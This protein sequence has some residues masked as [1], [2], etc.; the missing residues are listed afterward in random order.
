MACNSPDLNPIENLWLD[1]PPSV[2]DKVNEEVRH[3]CSSLPNVHLV[4]HSSIR[5]WH[6]YDGLHLNQDGVRIFAKTIKD[7]ALGRFP[8]TGYKGAKRNVRLQPFEPS[9]PSSRS[10]PPQELH[11]PPMTSGWSHRHQERQP[12]TEG[13]SQHHGPSQQTPSYAQVVSQQ[14]PSAAAAQELSIND[15]GEI[16]HLL[17]LLCNKMLN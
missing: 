12:Y 16:K 5:P 15:M 11:R 3:S 7:V 14:T 9:G 8:T 17:S 6:L 10:R 13:L 2:I 4:H 1:V